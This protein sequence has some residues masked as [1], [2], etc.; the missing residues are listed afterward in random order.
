M[1]YQIDQIDDI[2]DQI[3]HDLDNLDQ[4][5]HDLDQPD[6]KTCRNEM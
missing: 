1:I 6:P 4:T 5:D 2:S 3:D